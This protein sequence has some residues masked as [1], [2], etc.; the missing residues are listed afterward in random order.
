MQPPAVGIGAGNGCDTQVLVWQGT[1]GR[2]RCHGKLP[3]LV[4]QY[5]DLRATLLTAAHY[6]ATDVA[7]GT[8][9][10]CMDR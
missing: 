6:Y 10:C 1:A 2:A 5:A 7:A 8:R 4:K 3:R 9:D